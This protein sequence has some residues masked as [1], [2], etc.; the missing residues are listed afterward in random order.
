[1][2]S[3]KAWTSWVS[4]AVSSESFRMREL[5]SST[6]ALRPSMSSLSFVRAILLLPIS[7][8]QK[9][10]WS[11]SPLASSSKRVI[12]PSIIF[13]TLAKGSAI[14]FSASSVRRSLCKSLPFAS[15][16][17][18]T[19]RRMPSVL[20]SAFSPPLSCTSA[21]P[22]FAG[23]CAKERCCSAAPRTSGEERIS[24]ALPMASISSARSC[25]FSWKDMSFSKHSEVIDARVFSLEALSVV[26]EA[27]IF[28]ASAFS[29]VLRDFSA[30]FSSLSLFLLSIESVKSISIMS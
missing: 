14:I 10:S 16:K 25:C 22:F 18:R 24:M 20:P 23:A 29:S 7:V 19:R 9:P 28:S 6:A 12:M 1:M 2:A 8:S 21:M 4:S 27:S 3:S 26:S 11:A 30:L 17:S 5:P 13:L 15:R